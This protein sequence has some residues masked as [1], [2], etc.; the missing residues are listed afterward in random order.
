MLVEGT[1]VKTWISNVLAVTF[2]IGIHVLLTGSVDLG[3]VFFLDMNRAPIGSFY[4]YDVHCFILK[5]V[6]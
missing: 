4:E 1:L 5:L 2:E 6:S 3:Y